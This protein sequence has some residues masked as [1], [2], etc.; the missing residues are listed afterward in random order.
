MSSDAMATT[1]DD[2]FDDEWSD[3]DEEVA[4]CIN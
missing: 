1:F 3:E 4:V 2:D